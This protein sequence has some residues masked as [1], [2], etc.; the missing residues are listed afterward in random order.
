[1]DFLIEISCDKVWLKTLCLSLHRVDGTWSKGNLGCLRDIRT[2]TAQIV[3]VGEM[4]VY[5]QDI[6]L[7]KKYIYLIREEIIEVKSS[8]FSEDCWVHLLVRPHTL[9]LAAA[10]SQEL[11]INA[12]RINSLD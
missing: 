8:R 10:L 7:I 1:M 5:I 4:A 12:F 2:D 9:P 3:H 6:D 11:F